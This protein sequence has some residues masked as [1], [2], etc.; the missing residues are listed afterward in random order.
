LVG[1]NLH[2]S[3]I[4]SPTGHGTFAM[5]RTKGELYVGTSNVVIPVPK[6]GFPEAFQQ[7]SRLF[8][9]ARLFNS[10][11]LNSTFYKTPRAITFEKWAAEVPENF[12]FSIKLTREA[13]HAKG[14]KFNPDDIIKLIDASLSIGSRMGC[15]LIQ[16]PGKISLDYFEQVESMLELLAER[17]YFQHW[18]PAIEFRDASWYTRE[19]QELLDEFNASLVVHDIPKSILTEPNKNAPFVYLRFHGEKGDYRGSYSDEALKG[20]ARRIGDWRASGKDV[21]AYFNNTVGDAFDN[22]HTLRKLCETV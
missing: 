4:V 14:L 20:Y 19:T 21:Y 2:K 8:Y 10:V 3:L 15:L 1:G 6:S 12:R 16:F 11:E 22:A 7:T 18:K 17:E 5:K 9:Y 13:T